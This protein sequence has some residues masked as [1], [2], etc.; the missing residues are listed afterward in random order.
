MNSSD[1]RRTNIGM[2]AAIGAA[3]AAS[4]CCIVPLGLVS[5]GIGGAWIGSL[6]ALEPFRPIFIAIAVAALGF[7]GYRE[8]RTTIA[9]DCDCE[10]GMQDHLRRSLLVVGA[11]AV[12]ALIASPW[13]IQTT[14]SAGE[15]TAETVA[16]QEIVLEVERMTCASCSV[17]VRK[18]LTNLDGVHS[19]EVTFEPPQAVV[20]FD[21][22]T[23][24]PEELTRATA[25][26]GYP[27]KVKGSS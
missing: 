16:M 24:T 5:L 10:I 13:L 26:V 12:A 22:T 8:Y 19:A 23:V 11:L 27:S 4:I 21:A 9:P 2:F 18:A 25:N 14:A 1:D 15:S 20:R 6:T 3:V 17:T 7:A